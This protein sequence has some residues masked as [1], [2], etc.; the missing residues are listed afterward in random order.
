MAGRHRGPKRKLWAGHRASSLKRTSHVATRFHR[1]VVSRAFSA[2]CVYPT[3]RHHLHPIDLCAKFPFF[4]GLH[5]WATP[6]RKIAHSVTHSLTQSITHPA[7]LMPREPKLS[8]RNRNTHDAS[9]FCSAAFEYGQSLIGNKIAFQSKAKHRC[10][11]YNIVTVLWLSKMKFLYQGI[12]KLVL[13]QDRQMSRQTRL[14]IL[15][16]RI[17][18]W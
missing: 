13:E 1:R 14:K 17:R 16:C 3:F 10:V 18:G 7:Y 12:Q 15:P 2:L 11:G 4:R 9:L 5:C 8:L 6:W